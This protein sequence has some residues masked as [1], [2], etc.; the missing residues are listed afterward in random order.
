MW[1]DRLEKYWALAVAEWY[2]HS[3][4]ENHRHTER[5][6]NRFYKDIVRYIIWLLSILL[7]MYL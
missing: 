3:P 7:V 6:Y 2:S 1:L 4:H 5:V